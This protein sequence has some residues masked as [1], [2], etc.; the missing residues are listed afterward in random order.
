MP[1]DPTIYYETALTDRRQGRWAEALRN[2]ER[3]IELDPRNVAYLGDAADT[4]SSMRR[5]GEAQRI[6]RRALALSPHDNW[7]RIFLASQPLAQRAD[8]RPLRSELNAILSENPDSAPSL[9]G[10]L[11]LCAMVERDLAAAERVLAAAPP[12]GDRGYLGFIVPREWFVGYAARTFNRP[13]MA[14]AAFIAT[15]AMVEK[16]LRDNPDN[17]LTWALLGEVKAALGEKQE[18]I[19]AGQRACELWPL[20]REPGWGLRTLR[21]LAI[22]YASVGEKDLA[23]QQLSLYAGQPHFVDYGELKLSPDWDPLRGDPRFEKIVASLAPKD[24]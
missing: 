5:Y 22:I 21:S 13:E 9:F 24:R 20:S 17:G 6:G 1:N 10:E 4:C 19:A 7:L 12:E 8:P 16:Q 11:W 3:A 2:F 23:L 15:R 14:R 18:A